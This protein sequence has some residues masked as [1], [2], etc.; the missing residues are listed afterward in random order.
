MSTENKED[1]KKQS[2]RDFLKGAGA[3]AVVGA[4][5]LAGVE[6]GVRIPAMELIPGTSTTTTTTPL[7]A[8]LSASPATVSAGSAV[9]FSVTPGGGT[10]PYTLSIDCGDG[11]KLTA[12]G[13]H[14]YAGAGNYTALLTVTDSKGA[15]TMATATVTVNALPPPA[16][17]ISTIALEV[18]GR[19]YTVPVQN[20]WTLQ[21]VLH[22]QLGITSV[23]DMC[24]G[25]GECGSC[26][27]IVGGRPVLSCMSLAV[28]FDGGKVQTVEGIAAAGHPIVQSWAD[29]DGMQCG[30]CTPGAVVT[31]KALLD[32]NPSPTKDD[33]NEFL[34]GNLC[35]C[36]TYPQWS[37]AALDAA[38]KVKGGK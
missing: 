34:S 10:P 30:Y 18:N 12:A 26:S 23:K 25:K 15:K 3:G 22:D 32:R 14:A 33:V 6:E 8:S 38:A 2:R 9:Q 24:S 17:A 7:A 4:V 27:V 36:G 5:V 1:K 21:Q 31:A 19:A 28:E 16:G 35:V 13:S 11:S 29:F 37:K 20:N